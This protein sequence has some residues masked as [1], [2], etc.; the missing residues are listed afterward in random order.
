[1]RFRIVL[2][3]FVL[4][5]CGLPAESSIGTIPSMV[6]TPAKAA[7]DA[8]ATVTVSGRLRAH[9][10]GPLRAAEFTILRNGVI[11]P[12]AK[13]TL[14]ED[15]SFRV[16]VDPG[17]YFISIAAVDHAQV[18]QRVL[19]ERAVAVHGNLGTYARADPRDTLQLKT[20]LLGADGSSI[21]TGP[22]TAVRKADGA[23]RLDLKDKPKQAVEM[24]YQL[25]SGGGRTYNGPLADSYESDGGGD[26][27]SVVAVR[28]LDAIDLDLAALP[29]AGKP[30]GLT[31][32][33]EA[34]GLLAVRAYR[35]RWEPRVRQ[36]SDNVPRKEGKLFGPGEQDNARMAALAVEALAEADAAGSDEGRM[37]LRLA[38]L[39]LFTA[40]DDEAA[41]RTR[42]GWILEHVDPLDPRL[43]L[44]MNVN[45]LLVREI[46]SADA[47][48][49]ARIEDWFGGLQ[50]NPDLG[51][52]LDA[53]S[54]LI[55][56]AD[57]RSDDTRV[58][59]LYQ[60]GCGPRFAGMYG[61]KQ[62][63]QRF[64]PDRILQ[65]GK[66]FPDF[67]FPA[68]VTGGRP[69]TRAERADRLYLVEFWAT[70]CAPC[71]A[72]M[73]VLHA[74]YAKVNDAGPGDGKD[75]L[76]RLEPVE[77]P[78]IEFVFV[79][80]DQSSGDVQR[81]RETYWSMPWLHAFVGR[82]DEKEVMERYGFSGVPTAV[83]VDST[84]TIVEVGGALRRDRLLPTLERVLSRGGAV[85]R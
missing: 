75:G 80:L 16:E 7:A 11:E 19:V 20:E 71:V 61:S 45:N 54:V 21:A 77:R 81:F 84:G 47:V 10:G 66:P 40:Y 41:A 70:W 68:L 38:H 52:A 44:F 46:S 50:A 15:G 31:W 76:R 3:L 57:D 62:L 8:P 13:G 34:P 48:F 2:C 9:D 55:H 79:S 65:R 43:G 24:R 35:D 69:I 32:S 67:E 12:T 18:V 51:T 14:A 78:K 60:A 27:W 30:A 72:E 53:I 1:M 39:E 56:H 33:G 26:Y 74:A 17:I 6:G 85:V 22:R 49:S 42:A 28:D 63:A 25:V 29:P 37:L 59:E 73:P 64:D 36:L 4:G 58:A 5:A 83:L 23:Y 82:A